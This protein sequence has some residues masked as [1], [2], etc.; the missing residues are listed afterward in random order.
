M[1][2]L[3][4]LAANA[5][6]TRPDDNSATAAAPAPETAPAS[7]GTEQKGTNVTSAAKS[8]QNSTADKFFTESSPLSLPDPSPAASPDPALPGE[9][10]PASSGDQN[11]WIAA[12]H[13][14]MP[15]TDTSTNDEIAAGNHEIQPLPVV[16]DNE[17]IEWRLAGMGAGIGI[18]PASGDVLIALSG[19][20]TEEAT[21]LL[22]HVLEEALPEVSLGNFQVFSDE[23]GV[24]FHASDEESEN[25]IK[26][27]VRKLVE[28]LQAKMDDQHKCPHWDP[29]RC[30]PKLPEEIKLRRW[31]RPWRIQ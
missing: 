26:E 24:F 7:P 20:S 28:I 8:G 12:T 25:K 16:T 11:P 27:N 21:A 2:C 5:A 15:D 19:M 22:S 31:F 18:D 6:A 23:N 4:S 17:G 14:I 9:T 29:S 30:L 13:G 10:G 3:S 1:I